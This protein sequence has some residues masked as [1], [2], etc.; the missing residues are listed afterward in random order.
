[1]HTHAHARTH[2]HT[3]T[4][5][6][7][8]RLRSVFWEVYWILISLTMRW[9]PVCLCV[10]VYVFNLYMCVWN[11]LLAFIHPVCFVFSR[12][13]WS[14]SS[15]YS[16]CWCQSW[17]LRHIWRQTTRFTVCQSTLT[18][19]HTATSI[20]LAAR[21]CLSWKGQSCFLNVMW[22]CSIKWCS[23]HQS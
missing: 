19:L 5:R 10:A 7:T 15:L 17:I 21:L 6:Y 11:H 16:V 3:H 9:S 22:C 23:L 12:C 13:W 2:T 18:H 20:L 14:R 4:Q 8:C 1:M